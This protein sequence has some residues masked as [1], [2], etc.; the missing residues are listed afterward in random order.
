ICSRK[1]FRPS[2]QRNGGRGVWGE[3]RHSFAKNSGQPRRLAFQSKT[4]QKNT[5]FIRR[6]RNPARAK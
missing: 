2:E 5:L 1:N 4:S 3:F 6:K